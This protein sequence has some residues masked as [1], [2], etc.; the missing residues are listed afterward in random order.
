MGVSLADPRQKRE[1]FFDEFCDL[2]IP[3]LLWIPIECG[4]DRRNLNRFGHP[5]YAEPSYCVFA[6]F[7]RK[8]NR[9]EQA[10]DGDG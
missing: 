7:F 9:G 4:Q 5:G 10:R 6:E 1:E 8:V 2:G 3:G